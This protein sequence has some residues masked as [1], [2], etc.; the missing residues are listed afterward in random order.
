MTVLD[1]VN[2]GTTCM[3]VVQNLGNTCS[4][5]LCLTV[6][7]GISVNKL[8]CYMSYG[9][10]VSDALCGLAFCVL[11]KIKAL[12]ISLWM[13]KIL[14]NLKKNLLSYSYWII[15]GL[16]LSCIWTT[17]AAALA[18]L[19]Y[20]SLYKCTVAF[21]LAT[22]YY[23]ADDIICVVYWGTETAVWCWKAYSGV[24]SSQKFPRLLWLLKIYCWCCIFCWLRQLASCDD[25]EIERDRTMSAED[26]VW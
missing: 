15:S 11:C 8:I 7:I 16:I 13:V 20:R 26:L 23:I 9:S 12:N 17:Q 6:F 19:Y 5:V 4:I 2:C 24:I 18:R 14:A 25:G 10:D 21:C 3:I 1:C 22:L